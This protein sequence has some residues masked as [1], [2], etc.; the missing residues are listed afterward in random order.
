MEKKYLILSINPGSTSTKVTVFENEECQ[1]KTLLS[2]DPAVLERFETVAQQEDFRCKIVL[3]FLYENS[4]DPA[5]LSAVVGRGGF[6]PTPLF[7]GTYV[8]DDIVVNTIKN[9]ATRQHAANLGTLIAKRIADQYEIPAFMVDP[10]TTDETE[11]FAHVSGLK[12]TERLPL[13]HCLN[14]KAVSRMAANKIGKKYEG[15]NL[16]VAHMGGGISVSAHKQGK[17]IDSTCGLLGEGTFSTERAGTLGLKVMMDLCFD[18]GL[19]RSELERLL[20]TKSGLMSYLGTNDARVVEKRIDEG[21][22]EA[23][24]YYEALAYQIAKDIGA[25]ATTLRGDVDLIVLTAGL[26]YSERLVNWIKERVA[27]IAPIVVIPGE[28]EHEAMTLGALRV[29]RGEE[30][31]KHY[32]PLQ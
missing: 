13:F 21:D 29:L 1:Y 31:P 2:H 20:T 25:Q 3:D 30:I 27:F 8:I 15:I 12:E 32:R 24:F 22:T 11:P 26:A 17:E 16:I 18:S 9:H 19:S 7:S 28:Y 23:E 6:L 10:V 4:I 14:V 5:S